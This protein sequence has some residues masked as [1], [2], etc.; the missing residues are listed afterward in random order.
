[1]NIR[2][3]DDRRQVEKVRRF[4]SDGASPAAK[5]G[6][7]LDEALFPLSPRQNNLRGGLFDEPI[8]HRG[9]AVSTPAFIGR[10]RGGRDGRKPPWFYGE[11]PRQKVVS[12]SRRLLRDAA[13]KSQRV[14]RHFFI[15]KFCDPIEVVESF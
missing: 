14:F 11:S 15:E 7:L 1:M 6:D 8:D 3:G 5:G 2:F 10:R 13:G 4:G 9:V 12:A